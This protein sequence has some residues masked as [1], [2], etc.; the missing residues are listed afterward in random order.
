MKEQTYSLF[1]ISNILLKKKLKWTGGKERGERGKGKGI[2]EYRQKERKEERKKENSYLE[3]SIL[4]D[5]LPWWLNDK[6]ST[7]NSKAETLLCQQ[8]FV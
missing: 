3:N 8:R 5:G 2:E 4:I 1:V 6:E 7:Y